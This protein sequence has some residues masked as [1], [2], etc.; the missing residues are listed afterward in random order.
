MEVVVQPTE[1]ERERE[2]DSDSFPP[3]SPSLPA[4]DALV[5]MEKEGC[6]KVNNRHLSSSPKGANYLSESEK[7]DL[8]HCT[9]MYGARFRVCLVNQTRV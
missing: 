1:R 4:S 5:E 2:R 7:Q 9:G 8:S 6:L 3:S